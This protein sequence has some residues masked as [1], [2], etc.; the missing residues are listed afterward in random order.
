VCVCVCVCVREREC[1]NR[2]RLVQPANSCAM[3]ERA[4]TAPSY[5]AVSKTVF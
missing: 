2:L 4:V 3:W 1:Y 5:E